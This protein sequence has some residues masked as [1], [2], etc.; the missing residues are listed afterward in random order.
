MDTIPSGKT[1][2]KITVIAAPLVALGTYATTQNITTTMTVTSSFMFS[3]FMFSGDLDLPSRQYY[4]WN[5]LKFI[6]KPYQRMFNHR[7]IWTH[8][9][10]LGTVFRLFY[11]SLWILPFLYIFSLTKYS[12]HS[13]ME[14]LLHL[15]GVATENKEFLYSVFIGLLLGSFSHSIADYTLSFYKKRAKKIKKFLGLSN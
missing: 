15:K 4:R 7:S 12:P 5:I 10:L 1:H 3:G 14:L 2:D 13:F 9:V 11:L 8:G 6:W